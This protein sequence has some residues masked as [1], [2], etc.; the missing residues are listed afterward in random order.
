MVLC[1]FPYP[2][3]REQRQAGA[4]VLASPVPVLSQAASCPCCSSLHEAA[5]SGAEQGA[6]A[7]MWLVALLL[8][9]LPLPRGLRG[10]GRG[11][12]APPANAHFQEARLFQHLLRWAPPAAGPLP[13]NSLRYDVEYRQYGNGS[14]TPAPSC[15]RVACCSCDLSYETRKPAQRYLARVRAVAGSRASRWTPPAVLQPRQATLHLSNV[16]LSVSGCTIHV[17][18]Q[19]PASPWDNITYEDSHPWQREYHVH[20]RTVSSGA[21]SL[22]VATSLEFDLPALLRGERY[23]ISVEPRV[24]S[25]PNPAER[26]EEQCILIPALPD[27]AGSALAASGVSL[28]GL[29]AIGILGLGSGLACAY[30][31]KPTKTPHV[32]ESLLKCSSPWLRSELRPTGVKDVVLWVEAEAV[33][34]LSFVVLKDCSSRIHGLGSS[35]PPSPLGKSCGVSQWPAE[36][37]GVGDLMDSSSCSTDSGICLQE[38]S[39]SLNQ[40]WGGRKPC[41]DSGGH[42]GLQEGACAEEQQL[43]GPCGVQEGLQPMCPPQVQFSGYQKQSG[44]P[45]EVL[46]CSVDPSGTGETAASEPSL[47][48]GYLKQ[49][50]FGAHTSPGGMSSA[51]DAHD[52]VDWR[53]A[54]MP[55]SLSP[56]VLGALEFPVTLQALGFVE[57][58]T[59]L[60]SLHPWLSSTQPGLDLSALALPEPWA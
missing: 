55:G 59:A 40:L 3:L 12:P 42:S 26:T 46:G 22:H 13:S 6:Q 45:L 28:L 29:M 14:W 44:S 53:T 4:A 2:V 38:P 50:S 48:T 5:R 27:H 34:Q 30:V 1:S 8:P 37:D 19:L 10:H 16:S 39:G 58:E 51:E 24:V 57:Q 56:G 15:T 21:W 25:R 41:L 36:G 31:K 54:H 20:I 47:A 43:Q 17:S 33:Q 11:A 49:A 23:C 32:L 7:E 9:L 60:P 18:L 52:K 35:L